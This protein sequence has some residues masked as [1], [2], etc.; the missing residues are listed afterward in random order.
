MGE[1]H[2]ILQRKPPNGEKEMSK[3][4]KRGSTS[5]TPQTFSGVSSKKFF[6]SVLVSGALDLFMGCF[7]WEESEK[8]G[9]RGEVGEKQTIQLRFHQRSRIGQLI[10]GE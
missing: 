5:N 3:K 10:L 9:R 8:N 1:R 2:G 7:L 6:S 4:K